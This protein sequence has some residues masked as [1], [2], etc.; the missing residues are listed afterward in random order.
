LAI[1][2]ATTC[3]DL[4]LKINREAVSQPS[5][6]YN[7]SLLLPIRHANKDGYHQ[8]PRPKDLIRHRLALFG[9]KQLRLQAEI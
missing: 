1:G 7:G 8:T 3:V 5:W 9:Q 2:F 4:F 6:P